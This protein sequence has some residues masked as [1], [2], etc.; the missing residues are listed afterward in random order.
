MT[1][2]SEGSPWL[3]LGGGLVLIASL[4]CTP[5]LPVHAQESDDARELEEVVVTGS[6]IRRSEFTSASPVQI[7]DMDRSTLAGLV[8]VADVLQGSTVA[9]SGTQINNLFGGLVVDG[10]AGVNTLDLRGLGT[11]KTLVLMNGRR[12]N[13]AGTRGTVA[14]VDLNTLPASVIKRVEVLKDGASSVYGSDAVAGVVNIITRDDIEG[15]VGNLQM[16]VPTD[17]GG[18]ISSADVAY[19]FTSDNANIV[20]GVEW[21][22]RKAV[23]EGDRDWSRCETQNIRD[24]NTGE[25]LSRIDPATGQPKCENSP[26]NDYVV[27]QSGTFQGRWI[28]DS[29]IDCVGATGPCVPGW[30]IGSRA[31]R[32]FDNPRERNANLVS[33]TER[34]NFFSY[35]DIDL[36]SVFGGVEAYYEYMYNSRRSKQHTGPRQFAVRVDQQS[37]AAQAFSPF[38]SGAGTANE[39]PLLLPYDS[40]N[41]QEVNWTR[42]VAGLRGA[43]GDTSWDW[44]IYYA[45]GRSHGTYGSRQM[46]VD[47]VTNALDVVEVS[48][49]VYDCAINQDPNA[50]ANFNNGTC[51]PFNPY[52][53]I[54]NIDNFDQDVLNYLTSQEVGNTVFSQ[55]LVNGYATGRLFDLPAGEVGGVFGFEYR[56]EEI[57]DTP[58]SGSISGNLWGFTSSGVTQGKEKVAELYTE[59]EVPL[60]RDITAVQDLTLQLSG[61]Y[62]DYDTIGDDTTYKVGLNWQMIDQLRLRSSFGTSFRAPALFESFLGG[63]TAF[64]T[65]GDPCTDWNLG[66]PASNVYQNCQA[67]GLPVGHGGFT[68]TP[69]IITFGNAGRLQPETSEALTIGAVLEFDSIG[70]SLAVDYFDYEIVDEI[71]RFGAQSILDQCYRLPTG[72]FRNA[73]TVCDF[74]APRNTTT[75]NIS[76][77]NDSY[78]NINRKEV[79]GFDVTV[80]YDDLS[81]GELDLV[82][83]LRATKV[84]TYDRFLFGGAVEDLNGTIGQPDFNAQFD[85]TAYWKDW[86]FFYGLNWIGDQEDYTFNGIDPATSQFVLDTGDVIYHKVSARYTADNWTAQ[87]AV[88]NIG[89]EDPPIVSDV[90]QTFSGAAL[91]SG[92]DFRGRAVVLNLS[93]EF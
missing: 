92:Y 66:D 39:I 42:A 62:T 67:E 75:F 11:G 49:G 56:Q 41:E 8:D 60:L 47:R 45:Y 58:S 4:A 9:A 63:Q 6:R 1:D 5:E 82:A 36:S 40:L 90:L 3:R 25:D 71:D 59:F 10:G 74:I 89:D 43:V 28:R 12:L 16:S 51:V 84:E 2:R 46:L 83:D 24:P 54:G 88:T 38:F 65:A 17:T 29:A 78:F 19:G 21:F 7:I 23:N 30:R 70:L 50:S 91:Y 69:Q 73:G 76:D 20:F 64:S 55:H 27:V 52:A 26:A 87:I 79:D 80:R 93:V 31:E 68:S 34:I 33:P 32:K 85:L 53:Q 48:P 44:D 77:V 14:N 18:E 22:E 61:R 37:P 35:G 13:P 86:R 72:Q 15:F 81:F 57:E